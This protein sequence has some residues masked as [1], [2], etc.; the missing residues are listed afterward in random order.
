METGNSKTLVALMASVLV[1]MVMSSAMAGII[2]EDDFDGPLGSAVDPIKWTAAAP[3]TI[4]LDG[5]SRVIASGSNMTAVGMGGGIY[6]YAPTAGEYGLMTVLDHDTIGSNNGRIGL[7]NASGDDWNNEIVIHR[8]PWSGV[9][10]FRTAKDGVATQYNTLVAKTAPNM[11]WYIRWDPGRV[12][13]YLG[14]PSIPGNVRVDTDNFIDLQPGWGDQRLPYP[15][16]PTG[17]GGSTCVPVVPLAPMAYAEPVTIDAITWES[18]DTVGVIL[19]DDFDGLAGDPVNSAL[20][21]EPNAMETH[22]DGSSNVLLDADVDLV[23]YPQLLAEP[24]YGFKPYADGHVVFTA[25]NVQHVYSGDADGYTG[26]GLSEDGTGNN[27]ILLRVHQG[28]SW[29]LRVGSTNTPENNSAYFNPAVAQTALGDW[30]IEWYPT[31]QILVYF[32]DDLRID[33][34]VD[35]PMDILPWYESTSDGFVPPD[36]TLFPYAYK[37]GKNALSIG[38]IQFESIIPD[39]PPVDCDEVHAQ[40]YE[41]ASDLFPDCHIDLQDFGVFVADWLACNDPLDPDC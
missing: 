18:F 1:C 34:D 2:L 9:Y 31:G 29:V 3:P 33:T 22:L 38:K 11:N 32:N 28:Y 17:P 21:G 13:L 35:E 36:V 8:Q 26:V 27:E 25:D 23:T 40:G 39:L 4:Q 15:G 5:S 30:R 7:R 24:A 16:N 37:W 14:D 20:W 41:I 19:E 10:Y 12:R 6:G